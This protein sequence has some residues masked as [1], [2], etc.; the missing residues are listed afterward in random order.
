[1][2]I[3]NNHASRENCGHW[4]K[5]LIEFGTLRLFTELSTGN[6]DMKLGYMRCP[7]CRGLKQMYKIGG[8]YSSVDCG[9]IKVDCPMCLG[10]GE[11]KTLRSACE[12]AWIGDTDDTTMP[13]KKGRPRKI[14]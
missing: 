4:D 1:M 14:V 8:G 10:E 3:E 2:M 11:V 6:V 7:R 12:A 13:K 5:C 9:G